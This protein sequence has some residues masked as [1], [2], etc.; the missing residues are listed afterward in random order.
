M[1]EGMAYRRFIRIII[2]LCMFAM[3]PVGAEFTVAV[4]P[5]DEDALTAPVPRDQTLTADQILAMV[6]RA[7]DLIGGMASV[8][9]DTARLVAIKTN[10]STIEPSGSGVITDARVVRA[11]ALL[12]HE[13]VPEA[14]I[15]IVEGAG[16]W[17]ST[18]GIERR[19]S[20]LQ[21][22]DSGAGGSGWS[23]APGWRPLLWF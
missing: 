11:V 21:R 10:I 9:P 6:R 13:A 7:V 19:G 8:V 16:G 4:V 20:R 14:R 23:I 5:S 15:L 17:V 12:V 2:A 18:A 22:D 3:R 1:H